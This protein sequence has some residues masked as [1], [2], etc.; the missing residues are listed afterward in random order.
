MKEASANILFTA[1]D[2]DREELEVVEFVCKEYNINKY[3]LH[4]DE[5]EF[6][7]NLNAD[8]NLSLI[9]HRLKHTDG[10]DLTRK[11]KAI[12]PDNYVIV[13][14]LIQDFNVA[15][16]YLKAGAD[17]WLKKHEANYIEQLVAALRKGFSEA[18]HRIDTAKKIKLLEVD[19]MNSMKEIG[20]LTAQLN[21]R[22]TP[23]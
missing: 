13:S 7:K 15:V 22:K 21:P 19:T 9:D 8:I 5:D 6:L 2:D 1:I 4:T 12:N 10:L 16:A 17:D 11:V 3:Q 23:E 20:Q 14:S 18:Q